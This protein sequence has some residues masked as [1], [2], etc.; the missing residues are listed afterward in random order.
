M[1]A[2]SNE[3]LLQANEELEGAS[4]E[5]DQ[6]AN[7]LR[8]IV[9]DI[10]G[11]RFAPLGLGVIT[12]FLLSIVLFLIVGPFLHG[13]LANVSIDA[14]FLIGACT[15]LLLIMVSTIGFKVSVYDERRD[16]KI[17]ELGSLMSLTDP[18]YRTALETLKESDTP[19]AEKI[20]KYTRWHQAKEASK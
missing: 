11:L 1:R 18:C 12:G 15:P 13:I 7:R 4:E 6:D 19:L 5:R 9:D 14:A 2:T 3:G 10:E 16:Y 20:A 8:K 17:E